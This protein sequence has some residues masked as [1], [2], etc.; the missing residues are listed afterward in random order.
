M[1]LQFVA[2][3]EGSKAASKYYG[4]LGLL[5]S[6]V[7]FKTSE[8]SDTEADGSAVL[9]YADSIIGYALGEFIADDKYEIVTAWVDKTYGLLGFATEVLLRV[10]AA[11]LSLSLLLTT[12]YLFVADVPEGHVRCLLEFRLQICQ[13]RYQGTREGR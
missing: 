9:E 12:W 2:P 6:P 7:S 11:S 8:V 1:F 4:G 5:S 10:I 13:V 3:L